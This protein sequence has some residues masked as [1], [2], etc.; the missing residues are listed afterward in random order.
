MPDGYG[1]SRATGCGSPRWHGSCRAGT[2]HPKP[3]L[4][5]LIN[6]YARAA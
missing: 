3:V 5:G 6:E 1:T 2:D 4:G